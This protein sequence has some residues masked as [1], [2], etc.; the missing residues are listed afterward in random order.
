MGPF[1]LAVIVALGLGVAASM[2]L[3][4]Y[5]STS[6]RAYV[7]SG[8]RPDADSKWQGLAEKPKPKT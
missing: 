6:D 1:I 2:V 8:A 5:Q 3:D 4:R 7:G